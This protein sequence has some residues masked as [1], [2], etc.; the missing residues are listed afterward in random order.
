MSRGL[1][2]PD[3]PHV[4]PNEYFFSP[5]KDELPID[6]LLQAFYSVLRFN[7]GIFAWILQEEQERKKNSIWVTNNKKSRCKHSLKN[8]NVKIIIIATQSYY[9]QKSMKLPNSSSFT[10][11]LQQLR[12]SGITNDF[13]YMGFY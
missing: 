8:S 9:T 6:K 2:F 3:P 10:P 13:K 1:L 11:Q 5:L 7:P 4:N 12:A